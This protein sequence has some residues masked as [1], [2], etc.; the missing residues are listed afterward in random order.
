MRLYGRSRVKRSAMMH[1]V[2]LRLDGL[3]R[4]MAARCGCRADAVTSSVFCMGKSWGES[5]K[6]LVGCL[7]MLATNRLYWLSKIR[8][9]LLVIGNGARLWTARAH[10]QQIRKRC[11]SAEEAGLMG[12][13]PIICPDVYSLFFDSLKWDLCLLS[14]CPRPYSLSFC[15]FFFV[16]PK[17]CRFS[18]LRCQDF[19]NCQYLFLCD[20][21]FYGVS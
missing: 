20:I 10:L 7:A 2:A 12:V 6:Y 11:C 8:V 13:S 9:S 3:R 1:W 4:T 19:L 21:S 17:P 5:R 18:V 16:L 15:F 14:C